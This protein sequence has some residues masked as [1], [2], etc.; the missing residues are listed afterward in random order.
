MAYE[1]D[2]RSV[3]CR[4]PRCRSKNLTVCETTA[5]TMLFDVTDGVMTRLS[6]TD[7]FEGFIGVDITC[8]LCKHTWK[9]RGV[10]NIAQLEIDEPRKLAKDGQV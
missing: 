8:K 10:T 7:E 5:A 2:S 6:H 4:C 3:K 9:P 1:C